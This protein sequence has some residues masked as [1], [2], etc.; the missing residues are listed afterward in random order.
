MDLDEVARGWLELEMDVLVR[1][2]GEE[3]FLRGPMF[4]PTPQFFPDRWAPTNLAVKKVLER[5]LAHVG[6]GHRGVR[7]VQFRTSADDIV[8]DANGRRVGHARAGAC[9]YFAGFD[10][11][12]V[13]LFGVERAL[14][15]DPISV[16]GTLAHEVAHAY[17]RHHGLEDDDRDGEE[18]LTDLTTVFLG[19]GILTT[20]ATEVFRARSVGVFGRETSFR[21]GGYLSLEAMSH[22]LA[23]QAHRR[24]LSRPDVARVAGHLETAQRDA[25]R[26]SL[27]QLRGQRVHALPPWAFWAALALA[28]VAIVALLLA[29]RHTW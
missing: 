3:L 29:A 19:F 7:V 26:G 20:N 24:A 4:E 5:L 9:A 16:V 10:E 28:P 8:L 11:R 18:V 21:A 13:C 6:L 2:R 25:F 15:R 1:T 14:L 22:L 12:G 23:Y 17:R 27:A